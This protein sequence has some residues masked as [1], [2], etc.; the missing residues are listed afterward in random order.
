MIGGEQASG[1]RCGR[2]GS[3]QGRGQ[4]GAVPELDSAPARPYASARGSKRGWRGM[5]E[6]GGSVPA[7]ESPPI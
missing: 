7:T 3:E 6:V 2:Q 1:V 4:N 5:G